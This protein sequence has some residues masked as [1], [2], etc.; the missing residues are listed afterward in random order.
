MA[1]EMQFPNKVTSRATANMYLN[2]ETADVHFVF[3]I[4]D[5]EQRVAAHKSLLAAGSPVFHAM[6]YGT[7]KEKGD[8]K[9]SDASVKGFM[10]FLSV[11]YLDQVKI[12][13]ENVAEIMDL[14]NKYDI[15]EGTF[16]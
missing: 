15:P 5:M 11:F 12:N 14:S 16:N 3:E 8:V 2:E 6:F 9:I 10:D 13:K 7:I 4:D 1:T